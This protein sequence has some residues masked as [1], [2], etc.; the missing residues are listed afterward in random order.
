MPDAAD[1]GP[2]IAS[3]AAVSAPI[4]ELLDEPIEVDVPVVD[5]VLI[6]LVVELV[7][8]EPLPAGSVVELLL[9]PPAHKARAATTMA[10]GVEALSLI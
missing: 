5:G 2:L 7:F 3:L 8:D 6:G 1:A 9:Q 10:S 4:G